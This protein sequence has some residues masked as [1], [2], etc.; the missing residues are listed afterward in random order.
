MECL[1]TRTLRLVVLAVAAFAGG[2]FV[3]GGATAT[4]DSLSPYSLL[5]QMARVLVLVENE[6]VEP[7]ARERLLEGSIKG[8]VAE[9]DPH[10]A[11]LP[12]EDYNIFQSDT[13]GSFGGI[14]VEVDFRDDG[15]LVIAPIEG[16]P[17]YRAGIL[18]GDRIIAIDNKSVRGKSPDDL[19]RQMRGQAGT[20]VL[21][22]VRREGSDR[23]RY[24]KLTREV[25]KVSS[26][27]AKLLNADVGYIRIKQFQTGTHSELLAATGKLR[28]EAGGELSGVLLDMRN[29]PGGLVDEAAAVADEFLSGGVIY[30]TRRRGRIVEEFRAGP[31]GVLRR[32]PVVVLVNEYS[33]SA[34]ELVA[35][36]LM[37]RGRAP[38]VGAPTFGKGSVQTIIDLPGGAGLR[39]TTMRYYTP[40]GHAIQARGIQPSVVIKAAY[41]ENRSF[42]VVREADLEGHLPTEGA[43]HENVEKKGEDATEG[44]NAET[45]DDSEPE[46]EDK[47]HLGV[48]RE[49]PGNPTGGPD[50]QLSV[51]YQIVTGVLTVK[52]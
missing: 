20:H 2:A 44:T 22:T 32:G 14:G 16:S 52:Q 45:T 33:A 23:L 35:G 19:I 9:L 38:V 17:A 31:K 26:I 49:I 6:Y 27:K 46:S 24:F 28:E 41:A 7:V 43:R 50:F 5:D 3:S 12:A 15:V 1:L 8:M 30:T 34:A 47:T 21:L 10:S 25:I 18:S 48:A 37:D 36:A 29:N 42:G 13:Q 40:G 39:L 11:Y 4:T 51:A